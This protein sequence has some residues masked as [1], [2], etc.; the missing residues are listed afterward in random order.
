MSDLHATVETV[1]TY[2]DLPIDGEP[3]IVYH[4]LDDDDYYIGDGVGIESYYTKIDGIDA[5]PSWFTSAWGTP[6]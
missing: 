2:D 4:V 6:D 1:A 5:L 3:A